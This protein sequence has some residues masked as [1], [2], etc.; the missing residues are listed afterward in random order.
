MSFEKIS[1]DLED[2]MVAMIVPPDTLN[3]DKTLS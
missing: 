2:E 1:V 3:Q